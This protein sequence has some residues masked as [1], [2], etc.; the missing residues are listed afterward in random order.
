MKIIKS[1]N[2]KKSVLIMEE[3]ETKD[4]YYIIMELCISNLEENIKNRNK[5][6]SIEE[7]KII[8]IELNKALKKM[9][10]L[11]RIHGNITLSNILLSI[12]KINKISIKLADYVLNKSLKNNL[13]SQSYWFQII[14]ILLKFY[15]EI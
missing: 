9:N 14:L 13:N 2:N 5:L 8:L 11:K 1:L 10:E 12:D 6:L 15:K 7:I 3:I 4:I